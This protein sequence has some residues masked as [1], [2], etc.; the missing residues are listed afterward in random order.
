MATHSSHLCLTGHTHGQDADIHRCGQQQ[1]IV[2]HKPS[3]VQCNETS[4]VEINYVFLPGKVYC[5]SISMVTVS[6][7]F[8]W[9]DDSDRT[10][11]CLIA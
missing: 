4:W 1:G 10:Y 11:Y 3:F 5:C 7:H 9:A 6:R 8:L 2:I